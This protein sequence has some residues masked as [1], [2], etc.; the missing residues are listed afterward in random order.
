MGQMVTGV[1]ALSGLMVLGQ[2][3]DPVAD[4]VEALR[5]AVEIGYEM[6]YANPENAQF[7]FTVVSHEVRN[8][9]LHLRTRSG[10][11]TYS[12]MDK[13]VVEFSIRTGSAR[14]STFDRGS[15]VRLSRDRAREIAAL[16]WNKRIPANYSLTM[17]QFGDDLDSE[18][19]TVG[20]DFL[21]VPIHPHQSTIGVD[22]Y[23]GAVVW[24]QD[25]LWEVP[26]PIAGRDRRFPEDHCKAVAAR[27]MASLPETVTGTLDQ[28]EVWF[29][30][31]AYSTDLVGD[32]VLVESAGYF[33]MT[34]AYRVGFQVRDSNGKG[35]QKWVIVDAHTGRGLLVRTI[36]SS[37]LSGSEASVRSTPV[38]VG[39]AVIHFAGKSLFVSLEAQDAQPPSTEGWRRGLAEAGKSLVPVWLAPDG[40]TLVTGEKAYR[41]QS[42]LAP[43]TL[44]AL[45]APPFGT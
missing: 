34:P 23:S 29:I 1:L 43:D 3:S 39:Q 31:Y 25:E 8:D 19:F 11:A 28:G 44:K 5:E 37:L 30:P 12:L 6:P 2:T 41:I 21:G 9:R 27:I 16:V 38:T 7:D 14:P 10:Y 40:T 26:K 36:P 33:R 42:P 24:L 20:I 13:R 32:R 45:D 4:A 18:S 35:H 15:A 22:A 17:R